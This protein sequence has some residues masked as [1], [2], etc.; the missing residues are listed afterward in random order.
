MG[1]GFEEFDVLGSQFMGVH[2]DR[3]GRRETLVKVSGPCYNEDYE[4]C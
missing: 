1:P 4:G 2:R 3:L